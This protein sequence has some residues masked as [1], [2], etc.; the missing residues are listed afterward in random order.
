[1]MDESTVIYA[2]HC[3]RSFFFPGIKG[4]DP[5][6]VICNSMEPLISGPMSGCISSEDLDI[7]QA[8][9][10]GRTGYEFPIFHEDETVFNDLTIYIKDESSA[11]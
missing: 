10:Q 11:D 2:P 8:F 6:L 1:M 9:L 3:E 7:A 4:K 5:Q